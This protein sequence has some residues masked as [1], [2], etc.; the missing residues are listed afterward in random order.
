MNSRREYASN[1]LAVIGYIKGTFTG[2]R[3]VR[4]AIQTLLIGDIAAAVAFASARAIS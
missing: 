1:A 2:A 4:S 3:P